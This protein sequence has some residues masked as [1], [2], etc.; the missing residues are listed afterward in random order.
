M[1]KEET[2]LLKWVPL[3]DNFE[4]VSQQEKPPKKNWTEGG[5]RDGK[6]EC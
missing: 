6:Y 1:D 5:E 4:I 2:C 3:I